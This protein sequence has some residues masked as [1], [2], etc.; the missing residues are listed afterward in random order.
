MSTTAAATWTNLT[1]EGW[2][3]ERIRIA[4]QLDQVLPPR[5]QGYA[6]DPARLADFHRREAA[7]DLAGRHGDGEAAA[8]ARGHMPVRPEAKTA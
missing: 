7:A 2:A 1:P 3:P 8:V 5:L 4:E 6:G